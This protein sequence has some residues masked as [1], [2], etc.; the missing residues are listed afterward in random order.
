MN[1]FISYNGLFFFFPEDYSLPCRVSCLTLKTQ[2]GSRKPEG[3][4]GKKQAIKPLETAIPGL[5]N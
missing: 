5:K 2:K 4:T 1:E 3:N